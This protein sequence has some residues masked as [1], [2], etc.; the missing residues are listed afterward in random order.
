MTLIF[1]PPPR[2]IFTKQKLSTSA[3]EDVIDRLSPKMRRAVQ[4]AALTAQGRVDLAALSAA[5]EV[6]YIGQAV[7]QLDVDRFVTS[8]LA[9][10]AAIIAEAHVAGAALGASAIGW[11]LDV[12]NPRALAAAEARAARLLTAVNDE[13]KQTVRDLIARAYREHITVPDT[14]RLIRD[15]VGLN[16]RQA[17]ALFNFRAGLIEDAV[18]PDRVASLSARYAD[19]LLRDRADT[20]AQTEIHRASADGQHELWREGV[21]AGRIN[22][23]VALRIW[24]ANAGACDWCLELEDLNAD[25]VGVDEQFQTPDGDMIEGP[26]ESH[27]GCR[28]S[29]GLDMEGG[30]SGGE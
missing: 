16:N 8:D 1:H 17:T 14:A 2:F 11:A 5:L 15:V 26:E 20:I 29:T 13:T 18:H 30:A 4:R 23:T 25:G 21:R 10:A 28:C 9:E 12:T 7:R 3:L 27:V 6:G 24:I 19:R 22:P